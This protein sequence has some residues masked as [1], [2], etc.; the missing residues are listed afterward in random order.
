MENPDKYDIATEVLSSALRVLQAVGFHEDEILRLF[1]QVARKP[2]RAPVWLQPL[3]D[4]PDS[5][6]NKSALGVES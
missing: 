2:E 1:E 3:P 4:E 5:A 6:A